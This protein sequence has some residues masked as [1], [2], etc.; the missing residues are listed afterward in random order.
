MIPNLML[1]RPAN[2]P[3]QVSL[4]I[5]ICRRINGFI[6]KS[7]PASALNIQP[8]KEVSSI[9]FSYRTIPL[10]YPDCIAKEPI[11]IVKVD[12]IAVVKPDKPI[13]GKL[14]RNDSQ[15]KRHCQATFIAKIQVAIATARFPQK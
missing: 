6:R 1:F 7:R 5:I 15:G 14:V 11:D 8:G 4:S 12:D 9:G 3:L 10:A 2:H 13:D